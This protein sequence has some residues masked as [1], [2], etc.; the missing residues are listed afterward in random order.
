MY[1]AREEPVEGVGPELIAAPLRDGGRSVHVLEDEEVPAWAAAQRA[2]GRLGAGDLLMTVGAGDVTRL[3]PLI[4]TAL[5][6]AR[7]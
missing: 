6:D 5:E 1:G 4:L 7:P 3:G 2:A